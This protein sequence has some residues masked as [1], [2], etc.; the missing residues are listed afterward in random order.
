VS[1]IAPPRGILNKYGDRARPLATFRVRTDSIAQPKG[2]YVP[3]K[4]RFLFLLTGTFVLAGFAN[5]ALAAL[6]QAGQQQTQPS[7]APPTDQTVAPAQVPNMP[8]YDPNA[9]APSGQT[10]QPPVPEAKP[11]MPRT[12][13][14]IINGP[15]QEAPLPPAPPLPIPERPAYAQQR[16]DV[17]SMPPFHPVP[18]AYVVSEFGSTYIPVDSWMYPALLRLYSLGYLDSAFLDMRPW[19]R[20]SVLHMLSRSADDIEAAGEDSEAWNIYEA[21]RAELGPD[22]DVGPGKHQGHAELD[23]IYTRAQGIEGQPLRDGFG[24]GATIINDYGRPYAEGF[25]S[26]S[27]VSGRAEDGRFSFYFRGEYQHAP[28]YTGYNTAQADYLYSLLQIPNTISTPVIAVGPISS[29]NNLRI[30]ESDV[31]VHLAGHE[32]SF[33]KHDEWL[34]PA[35]GGAFAWSNNAEP[36]YAFKINRVEPLYIPWVSKVLGP[37]R[38]EFFVGELKGHTDPKAPWVHAEKFAFR[39]TGNFEFGFE[40]TV[41]WGGQG[42]EPI[43]LGTFW[44]SFI[45]ISDTDAQEKQCNTPQTAGPLCRDPGARFSQ[46]DFSY[47]VPY[48]RKWLTFYADT[49]CHD[50]ISPVSAPRR[51]AFRTGLYLSHFPGAPNFDLRVEAVSTDPST[52]N[53]DGTFFYYETIQKEGITNNG[54]IFGDAIGRQAKGAQAWLTYHI[55]PKDSVQFTYR[56]VN[57]DPAFIVG[58]AT[59]NQFGIDAHV[60]LRPNLELRGWLQYERWV[61]PFVKPGVQGDTTTAVSLTWSP[62]IKVWQ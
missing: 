13:E 39:P 41:I 40:R 52:S 61:A 51:A 53:P 20:L 5:P 27:G 50:D 42:H 38:Y 10:T 54:Q 35:V 60:R 23:S 49:F 16:P 18:T 22:D 12:D 44:H 17:P 56:N 21:L 24:V 7:S 6:Q 58:G 25:N 43:T 48:L 45:S 37:V 9:T 3:L 28:G 36:I 1:P 11:P 33:G 4:R 59:Q 31:A 62:K 32:I 34:G 14:V 47:R 57:T 55:N 8:P 46:F 30:L 2:Y 26:Y 19:T 15:P 29:A